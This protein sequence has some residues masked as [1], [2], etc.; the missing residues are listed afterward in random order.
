MRLFC[1][2]LAL[3]CGLAL[4]VSAAEDN[5]A[6]DIERLYARLA[7][8]HFP[9]EAAGIVGEIQHLR[10]HSGSDAADLLLGRAEAAR[11]ASDL[12]L[13][14]QLLD[15]TVDIDPDWSS[16]WR[17][18]ANTRFQSGDVAGA[19][20]DL[21]QTLKRDPRD[22]EAL[23]GLGA[24]MLDAGDPDAALSVYDRALK[25]APAYEPLKDARAR[26]ET[27][28]LRRTL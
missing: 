1:V 11:Q 22:I 17:E 27:E 28:H 9:D 5:S 24:L 21:A 12:P 14:L 13:A 16:A 4:P 18:R 3:A 25:L 8:T 19:M 26:A 23:S 6:Q 10:L 20:A 2:I 15:A 7:R